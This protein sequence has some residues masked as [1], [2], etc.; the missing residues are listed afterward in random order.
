MRCQ[1]PLFP[2]DLVQVPQENAALHLRP[3]LAIVEHCTDVVCGLSGAGP[4]GPMSPVT[5][6]LSTSLNKGV[7]N[8]LQTH[9]ATVF[10]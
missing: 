2:G 9:G 5:E 10:R 3:V 7:A 1:K 6:R 4:H 8:W